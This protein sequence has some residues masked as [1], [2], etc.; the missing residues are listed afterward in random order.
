MVSEDS[1]QLSPGLLAVHRFRDQSDRD[2]TV[3]GQM[4]FR[5][6]Q[7]ETAHELVEVRGFRG[8]KRIASEEWDDHFQ[9]IAAAMNC[10]QVHVL[11]MVVVPRVHVH[12]TDAEEL[13]KSVEDVDASRA[14][15]HREVVIDL[16]A[17]SV[18][19]SVLSIRLSDE[20]DGEA[21]FSVYETS[22]PSWVDRSF[23]LIVWLNAYALNTSRVVAR[24]SPPI[25]TAA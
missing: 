23:L 4:R 5:V 17:G 1:D 9:K 3:P 12:A 13:T 19:F 25:T 21:S 18:A 8:A 16:I 7:L 11:P 2:Q 20:A 24:H 14:L 6:D 22:D 10:V 15:H